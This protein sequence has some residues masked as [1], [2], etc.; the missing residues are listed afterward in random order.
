MRAQAPGELEGRSLRGVLDDPAATVK[1]CAITQHT[2]P[3]Y[4][5]E[6]EPLAVMGYSMRTDRY[7]YAEWRDVADGHVQARELYD[8][9]EDP[10]ETVNLADHP[11]HAATIKQLA[12]QL[13]SVIDQ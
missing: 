8:H 12:S 4:P 9:R 3:A 2:R 11:E 1:S 7:R 6:E 10:A 13:A 5:S